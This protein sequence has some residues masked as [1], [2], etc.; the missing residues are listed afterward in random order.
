MNTISVV[1]TSYNFRP[2]L[3]DAVLSLLNQKGRG[4]SQLIVIDDA[5]PAR[6]FEVIADLKD[7]RLQCIVHAHNI[8][9]A[10]SI[11]EAMALVSSDYVGRYDG[12][13]R[14][15]PEA[16]E[17]LASAL[18]RH[19]EAPMAYGDIRTLSPSG[20]IGSHGIERPAGPLLRDEFEYLLARH[21]TCAPAILA[22]RSAWQALLPW[23]ERFRAGLGD[24]YFNLRFARMGPLVH[25]PEVLA[26][27]RVH[28]AGM[29]RTGLL[30]SHLESSL[31][32]ILAEHLPLLDDPARAKRIEVQHLR[33]LAKSYFAKERDDDA[34]RIYLELLRRAPLSILRRDTLASALAC[35][36]IGRK[37][38]R[39]AQSLRAASAQER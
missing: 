7:P 4:L 8:G 29:H 1:M 19:P 21:Y 38:Y 28:D 9:A 2:Y 18:D 32:E 14:W 17:Q 15:P 30:N 3:R 22:R 6:D 39:R 35:L 34:R 27:Y 25:V 36:L 11:N 12:D 10:Q 5:S 20:E 13:D 23:P 24:W 16:M 26:H 31:R 37:W 33:D